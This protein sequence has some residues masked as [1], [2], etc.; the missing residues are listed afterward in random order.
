MGRSSDVAEL[1]R[2]GLTPTEIAK[3]LGV[4]VVSV[5]GYLHRAV[6]EGLLRRSDIYFS[7]AKDRRSSDLTLKQWYSEPAHALGDMYEDLR[8][9]ETTLHEKIREALIRRFGDTESG[10]WRQGVPESVRLKCQERREKDTDEPCQVFCYSD[11]LDLDSVLQDQWLLL[12]NLFPE[13]RANRKELSKD[14]RKLNR[15]RNQ[16]MHPVRGWVPDETDFDFVRRL[17]RAL[18]CS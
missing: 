6:G 15:I 5:A 13:Y 14:L 1:V 16:I 8:C 3:E 11:L 18:R 10:W 7:V 2:R 17:Q 9:I 4:T 12:N